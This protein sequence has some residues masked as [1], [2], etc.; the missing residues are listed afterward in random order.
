MLFPT[1]NL[2]L[3]TTIFL[4]RI[5][6]RRMQRAI[7]FYQ[8]SPS[9]RPSN[10]D[11]VSLEWTYRQTFWRSG[12]DVTLAFLVFLILPPLQ[13]A[14]GNLT[15]ECVV[16]CGWENMQL[17]PLILG[18]VRNSH[19]YYGSLTGSHRQPINPCRFRWPWVTLKSGTRRVKFSPEDLRNYARTVWPRTTTFGK[20]TCGD[21]CISTGSATPPTQGS[22]IQRPPN[23][24]DMRAQKSNQI[25]Y[26]D[27]TRCEENFYRVDHAPCLDQ[28]F[29]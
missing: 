1:P 4:S 27:Q 3:W 17:S 21:G 9:V 25:L 23:F 22:W 26:D 5:I 15:S 19:C 7:L 28:N 14:N 8:F 20:V 24:W 16:S 18:T 13:N 6:M 12:G 2:R 29:W 10:A 11:I